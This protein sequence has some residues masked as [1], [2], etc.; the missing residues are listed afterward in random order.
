M[1]R[2]SRWSLICPN[3]AKLKDRTR[4][5][6]PEKRHGSWSWE[7]GQDLTSHQTKRTCEHLSKE[8][9]KRKNKYE[10]SMI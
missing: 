6:A 10:L 4:A 2:N 8:R 5:E 1:Y 3:T 9:V 7:Q